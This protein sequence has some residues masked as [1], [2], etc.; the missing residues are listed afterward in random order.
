MSVDA[1]V[2][3]TNVLPLG[4]GYDISAN[5]IAQ[6]SGSDNLDYAVDNSSR[7]VEEDLN[8]FVERSPSRFQAGTVAQCAV[9][10]VA[11][12]PDS[13]VVNKADVSQFTPEWQG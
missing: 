1:T 4:Y 9:D 11:G 3:A 2:G 13:G 5:R 12:F 7:L 6:S 10:P 8:R